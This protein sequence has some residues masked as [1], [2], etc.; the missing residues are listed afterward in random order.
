MPTTQ[1]SSV[2][3]ELQTD[4]AL[5]A[6]K[7]TLTVPADASAAAVRAC[8]EA[9]GSTVAQALTACETTE[10]PDAK[11]RVFGPILDPSAPFT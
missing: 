5:G 11:A 9:A 8:L 7:L 4:S 3:V 10:H 1:P 6:T 2:T